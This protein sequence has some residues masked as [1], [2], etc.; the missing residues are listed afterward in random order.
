MYLTMERTPG[1]QVERADVSY[2]VDDIVQQGRIP[3]G[4]GR[5]REWSVV[6]KNK[7]SEL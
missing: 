5:N 4:H 6:M 1:N 2:R 7:R 3:G